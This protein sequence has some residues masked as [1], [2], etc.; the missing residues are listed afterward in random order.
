MTLA[1]CTVGFFSK[2]KLFGAIIFAVTIAMLFVFCRIIMKDNNK[3]E[4]VFIFIIVLGMIIRLVYASSIDIQV[5]SDLLACL[6]AAQNLL[7]GKYQ[8]VESSYFSRFPYQIPFVYY[9]FVILKVFGSVRALYIFN[10]IFSITT[11]LLVYMIVKNVVNHKT[12]LIVAA[13][14]AILPSSV[15]MIHWLYHHIISGVF[16][17]LRYYFSF[18]FPKKHL[19]PGCSSKIF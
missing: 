3:I 1:L 19:L 2:G 14:H 4:L 6:N 10:A 11:C 12:A 7:H 17:C 9:E 18:G 16:S 8:W 13:I 5:K 15:F